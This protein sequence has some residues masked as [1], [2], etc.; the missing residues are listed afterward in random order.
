MSRAAKANILFGVGVV[1]LIIVTALMQE[2]FLTERNM[3]NVARQMVTTGL[4]SIG[5]YVVIRSGGIDLS[6]GSTVAFAGLLAA[7]LQE[8]MPVGAA[9]AIALSVGVVVGLIN[10]VLIAYMR[11]QPF[12][13]TLAMMGAVRGALFIYSETPTYAT[14]KFFLKTLGAGKIFGVVPVT[15][16]IFLAC[17][18]VVWF[19]MNHTR[20]GRSIMAIGMNPETVRLAGVNVRAQTTLAYVICGF[21]AALAGVLLAARLG[22]SQPSVGV[23][24]EL[25]AI[26]A[27]VIGGG[28]LGGGGGTVGGMFGGVIALALIDNVLNLFNVQSYYQQIVKGVIILIAVLLRRK[29]DS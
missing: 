26:A 25:D 7:G 23:A 22:I 20:S 29:P 1:V 19:F 13:V 3:V 14:D 8:T 28:I 6:V 11:L 15:F 18:P 16:A 4:L 12:I 5:M 21:F 27:V 9:I 2:V 17:I 24:Y 10:G